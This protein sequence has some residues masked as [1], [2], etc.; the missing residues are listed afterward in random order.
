MEGT[1]KKT[2]EWIGLH[3]GK[4]GTTLPF[5]AVYLAPEY[6]FTQPHPDNS[7]MP[8]TEDERVQFEP[9]LF[10]LSAQ[11]PDILI[12]PGTIFYAKP[13]FRTAISFQDRFDPAT[14]T[15]TLPKTS[16]P[17]RRE[18]SLNKLDTHLKTIHSTQTQNDPAFWRN[19]NVKGYNAGP[20][21]VPALSEIQTSLQSRKKRPW[22]VRNAAYILLGRRRIGKYDKQTDWGE[23]VG[24][25]PDNLAFIPG[26]QK[27][28]PEVGGYRI[29]MEVCADHANGML[30][31]RKVT[32]LHFHFVVSDFV[33][34]CAGNA[35]MSAGG[36]FAHASSNDQMSALWHRDAKGSLIDLSQ[37]PAHTS[38][39]PGSMLKG[40]VIQ[41]PAPLVPP[42][43]QSLRMPVK[44]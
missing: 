37:S 31:R 42:K 26:S 29:G 9:E 18:R 7:R 1:L 16:D 38:G 11:F 5:K 23:A 3:A 10:G 44:T 19:W 4:L 33:G 28:C 30:A 35:A 27:H 21:Q 36:Y 13:L 25:S 14:G 2:Q 24:C 12:V 39:C 8:L 43:P 17:D 32:P 22:I 41:L 6:Y 40:Y 15:R 34:N 20:Y